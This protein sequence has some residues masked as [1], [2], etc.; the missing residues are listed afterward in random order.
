MIVD[1]KN[2][3]Y[4][5]TI[6]YNSETEEIEYIAE[7]IIDNRSVEEFDHI[8]NMDL[9]ECKWDLKDLEYMRDHYTSGKS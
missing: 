8:G 2:K 7:E 3:I 1:N 9:E 6:E 5:L 4:M